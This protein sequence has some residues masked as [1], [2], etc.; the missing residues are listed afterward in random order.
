LL[1]AGTFALGVVRRLR[2]IGPV[3][4]AIAHWIVPS[5]WPLLSGVACPL[6]VVAHGA[7]VRALVASPSVVRERVI[8]SLLGREAR[9]TFAARSAQRVCAG[10]LP[11]ALAGALEGAAPVAPPA[12]DV[13]DVA[14]RAVALRASLGL[15]RGERVAVVACR[16]IA[17]KRV[18]LAIDAVIATTRPT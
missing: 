16:L 9:F 10:G 13:P 3:D 6:E 1:A 2:H 8:R 4:R 5:A 11:P 14:A 15:A 18:Q 12:I 7:D 17:P